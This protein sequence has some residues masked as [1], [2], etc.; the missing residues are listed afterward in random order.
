MARF[1]YFYTRGLIN[2]LSNSMP[3]RIYGLLGIYGYLGI[4]KYPDIYERPG[5][6]EYPGIYELPW[7]L[8]Q[9]KEVIIENIK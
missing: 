2:F 6:Y 8:C 7:H 5:I 4:D 9:G 3:G 1:K